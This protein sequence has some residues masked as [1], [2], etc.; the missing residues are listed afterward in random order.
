MTAADFPALDTG[1]LA[2]QTGLFGALV[3]PGGATQAAELQALAA[4]AAVEI[5]PQRPAI[6]FTL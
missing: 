6:R 3:V 4:R 2:L 1:D 5:D